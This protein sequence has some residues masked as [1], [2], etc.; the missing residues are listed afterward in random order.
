M[1][2]MRPGTVRQAR[3]RSR[4][5]RHP[6]G[7]IPGRLTGPALRLLIGA[8]VYR[9][10][11]GP[12]A[13]LFQIGQADTAGVSGPDA[14]GRHVSGPDAPGPAAPGPGRRAQGPAAPFHAPADIAELICECEEAGLLIV[15]RLS[16]GSG[17]AAAEVPPV[18]VDRRTATALHRDLAAALRG[19]EIICAHLSAADYWQWRAAAW[20]QDRHADLH[21]LLEARYHLREAGDS[22]RAGALTEVVCAQLHAWG[23]LD[24]EAALVQETLTWLSPQSPLRAAWIHEIGKI[25]QTRG[26]FVEAER[27]YRQ[28]LAMFA[29]AGDAA[30]ASR[31]Q[32]R[33]GILAQARGDYAEAEHRYQQSRDLTRQQASADPGRPAEPPGRAGEPPG[34]PGEPPGRAGDAGSA[35]EAGRPDCEWPDACPPDCGLPHTALS[36]DGAP[37]AGQRDDWLP[38]TLLPSAVLPGL[39]PGVR[40]RRPGQA[41]TGSERIRLLSLLSSALAIATGLVGLS[42]AGIIGMPHGGRPPAGAAAVRPGIAATVRRQAAIWLARQV[43]R[44]AIV[45]CDPAMCAALRA[46]GL[47]AG[48]LVTLWSSAEDPLGSDVVVATAAVR[49]LLGGRLAA[50]YA[51]A[52]AAAFGLGKTRIQIRVVAPDGAVAYRHALRADLLARR[53]AGAQM[54][55][56]KEIGVTAAARKELAAGAVDARLLTTIAALAAQHALRIVG[57]ADSG[58]GA[59]PGTPLRSAEIS[60]SAAPSSARFIR[61]V[62]VFLRAQRP[63]YLAASLRA[64]TV[65]GQQAVRVGFAGPSPLGLL[66]AGVAST[67]TNP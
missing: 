34:P 29:R 15:H 17:A 57:F 27:R 44:S 38:G 23:E 55:R 66:T 39:L 4:A 36:G 2:S 49:S 63:P 3:H 13:L 7:G 58:P 40:P 11:A 35:A 18:F 37:D 30:A 56:N 45:S 22:D 1:T 21:D 26:N 5:G 16:A 20:P 52:V 33:L 59:A 14:S 25:A 31:S 6:A 51:P 28:S 54:L 32:H 64:G 8:S 19:D 53:T 41:R 43:S 67:E 62:L 47:P 46:Q 65:D 10:P 24:L 12:N 50:V 48:N 42:A 60:A 9:E 61:S